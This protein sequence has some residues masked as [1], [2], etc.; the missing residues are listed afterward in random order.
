MAL[1]HIMAEQCTQVAQNRTRQDRTGQDR[2]GQ[3]RPPLLQESGPVTA[4]TDRVHGSL[5][6]RHGRRQ[7][8]AMVTMQLVLVGLVLHP[9]QPSYNFPR[10]LQ[11][12]TSRKTTLGNGTTIIV[13]FELNNYKF[14]YCLNVLR[15]LIGC[16][17]AV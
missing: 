13:S 8:S 3:D 5:M 17:N 6:A 10:L 9:Q 11:L 4:G 12:L 15:F 14:N 2:T 1:P 7:K 16:Q